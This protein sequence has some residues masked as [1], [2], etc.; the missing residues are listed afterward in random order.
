MFAKLCYAT[1]A[2][3]PKEYFETLKANKKPKGRKK[4]SRRMEFSNYA[5]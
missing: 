5:N 4:V 2:V 3:N 1:L